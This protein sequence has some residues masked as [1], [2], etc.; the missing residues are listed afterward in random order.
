MTNSFLAT[1]ERY[2]LSDDK[3]LRDFA[4]R[5]LNNSHLGTEQTFLYALKAMDKLEPH[6]MTNSIIP[7]TK[8]MPVTENVLKEVIVRLNKKDNNLH[9]YSMILS[10]CDTDLI[11][12][13][14]SELSPF[15]NNE[16]LET[17]VSLYSMDTEQ[18]FIEVG[19]IMNTL[20]EDEFNQHLY[21]FGKRIFKELIH[22]GE[23]DES[24][25]WEIE[26]ALKE[27][28]DK[29]FLSYNSIYNVYLAG[30]IN[31][32]SLIPQLTELL[33]R[34]NEDILLKE[35]TETL[36]KIGS[37]EVFPFIE[38]YITNQD[39][40]ILAIDILENIKHPIAEEMLLRYFDQS[41]NKN[42]KA[43]LAEALCHQLSSKAIPKVAA[44]IERGY[45]ETLPNLTEPIYAN[46]VINGIYHPKLED[47]KKELYEK[48][49]HWEARQKEI[50]IQDAKRVKLGRNDPC[51]CGSGKK[52]KKCCGKT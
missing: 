20:E 32:T 6:P 29:N 2:I 38:K 51:P 50:A 34:V 13:Y 46:C 33:S 24:N 30:E 8:H 25:I 43:L 39:T 48:E 22:R 5:T 23:Y 45:D 27:E 49:A 1:V 37:T 3:F 44:L 47:W 36:I 14:Q 52:F 15:V 42:L 19:S 4:L 10:R 35:V 26:A 11:V 41:D 7:R 18:L 9:W 21:N 28:W 12:K 16:A 31:A 40:S 17:I